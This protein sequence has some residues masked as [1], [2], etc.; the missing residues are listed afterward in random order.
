MKLKLWIFLV[1]LCSL[2]SIKPAKA[3]HVIGGEL[4]YQ[5]LFHDTISNKG[6]YKFTM[7]LYRECTGT[8]EGCGFAQP[9]ADFDSVIFVTVYDKNEVQVKSFEMTIDLRDTIENNTYNVCL[10][11]PPNVCVEQAIY[12][13]NF[14]LDDIAG[15]YY[16][17]YQR[18]CR[19]WDIANIVLPVC[20]TQPD[21]GAAWSLTIPDTADA[22]CNSSPIYT[23][24]PPTIICLDAPFVYDHSATDLD[25]DSLVYSL[26]EAYEFNMGMIWNGG[27]AG[28]APNPSMF[29]SLFF[30]VPYISGFSASYPIDALPTD[31]FKI[32]AQTGL[33]T[34]TPTQEGLYVVAVCVSEYR[35][36][37]LLTTNKRDVQ[38]NIAGCLD[39]PGLQFSATPDPC[40]NL[41]MNFEYLGN[42]V[43]SFN[44]DFGVPTLS[45]DTSTVENP[46]YTYPEVGVY[47]VTIVVNEDFMCA[48]TLVV[49]VTPPTPL[50]ADYEWTKTCAF[51]TVVFSG[52]SDTN[53]FTGPIVNWEWNFGDGVS[54]T[55]PQNTTHAYP[56]SILYNAQ[57]IITTSEGCKDTMIKVISFFSLPVIDA[58]EDVFVTEGEPEDLLATG[59][60][61]YVWDPATFL[62]DMLIPNPVTTPLDDIQYTVTGTSLNGCR[63]R[64]TVEIFVVKA[65][66]IVPNA[67]SPNQDGNN[68]TIFL[69]HVGVE[70]LIEFRIFNR[71]GQRVFE[72]SDLTEGWDGNFKSEPQEIGNYVYYYKVRTLVGEVMEGS[73]DIALL[74]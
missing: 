47:P 36:G 14:W 21:V 10:F 34:G 11:S 3:T 37:K 24:F 38:F 59:A 12:E 31:S 8:H 32:D 52:Q 61:S 42:N 4:I 48:D 40:D 71:W 29:P 53:A 33:L 49:N 55:L 50:A 74:R 70:E 22:V 18:C 30:S 65:Q 5:C 62:D 25:G 45:D 72:A 17:T 43:V 7:K 27:L 51:D 20:P 73:G 39:D 6:F 54:D 60:N 19:N 28:A 1:A 66:V 57:L 58:G 67:F 13:D 26:C 23:N 2:A 63:G 44:W 35:N 9:I 69:I 16:V 64:D 46:V 41:M 15:G 68:D 56:D